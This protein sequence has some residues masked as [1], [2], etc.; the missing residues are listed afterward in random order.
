MASNASKAKSIMDMSVNE[1]LAMR[2]PNSK[3][4]L[5]R[6]NSRIDTSETK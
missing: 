4:A 3:S 5:P 2:V 6:T 1:L